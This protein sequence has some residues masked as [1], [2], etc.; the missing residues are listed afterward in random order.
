MI[1]RIQTIYLILA[2]VVTGFYR[3]LFRYGHERWKRIF[4]LCKIKYI[5]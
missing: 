5:L 4:I 1:Q 3:F 2:F